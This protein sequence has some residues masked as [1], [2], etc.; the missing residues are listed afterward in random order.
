MKKISYDKL[1]RDNYPSIFDERGVGYETR[2]L[3]E[4]EKAL[5]LARKLEEEILELKQAV[6]KNRKPEIRSECADVFSVLDAIDEHFEIETPRTERFPDD[7]GFGKKEMLNWIS[8]EVGSLRRKVSEGTLP[9]VRIK[10]IVN[11]L[12][13]RIQAL[14]LKTGETMDAVRTIQALKDAELG[15]FTKWICLI[16]ADAPKD[17][18]VRK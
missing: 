18:R 16:E 13:K 9:Y 10:K 3:N 6:L 14:I 5:Y 15:T 11:A 1:I 12:K 8:E 7:P 17:D 4:D 2:I